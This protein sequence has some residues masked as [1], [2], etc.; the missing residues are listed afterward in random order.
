MSLGFESKRYLSCTMII[1]RGLAKQGQCGKIQGMN[2]ANTSSA[3]VYLQPKYG[4]NKVACM[5]VA[6]RITINPTL[7]NSSI[8]SNSNSNNIGKVMDIVAGFY[9]SAIIYSC[10]SVIMMGGK[11]IQEGCKE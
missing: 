9:D 11:F 6:Q 5:P 4:K 3:I 7:L 2:D 8:S 1:C 10:G